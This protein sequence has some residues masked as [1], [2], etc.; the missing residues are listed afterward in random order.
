VLHYYIKKTQEPAP[1]FLGWALLFV[2]IIGVFFV[3]VS[4]FFLFILQGL[5][6]LDAKSA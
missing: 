1:R 4:G 5:I 6:V 3:P 2:G